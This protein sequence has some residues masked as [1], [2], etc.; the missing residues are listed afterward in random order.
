MGVTLHS[1]QKLCIATMKLKRYTYLIMSIL[2]M[3]CQT[4]NPKADYQQM[5][6][7]LS[8]E[9]YSG[10]SAWNDGDILAAR[11]L[12]SRLSE[13]PDLIPDGA[14]HTGEKAANP[15]Y[16]SVVNPYD[17]GRW[18]SQDQVTS[19]LP[20]LQHFVYPMNVMLGDMQVSVDGKLLTPTVDYTAKEFSPTTHGTYRV[21]YLSDSLVTEEHFVNYLNSGALKDAFAVINFTT[22][23]Q[24]PAHPYERYLPYIGKLDPNQI[25][26]IILKD[27]EIFPYFKARSYYQT[28]VPVLCVNEDFP[29]D[30]HQIKVDIDAELLPEKDAHNVIA[31]LPGTDASRKDYICFIA[32]Y[33]H[34]GLMGRD[35]LFPGANDNASGVAMLYALAKHF[36]K[37]R[38]ACGVQFIWLDAEEENLL[39]AFY[40][41]ENPTR[42]LEDIRMVIDLDMVADNSDHLATE[43]SKEGIAELQKIKEINASNSTF[44]PFD[45]ALQELS[46]ASDHYAF[47]EKGV[48]AVYFSTEG[49]FLQ[50]Y[51]TPRDRKTLIS[52]DNFE[53]LFYLIA[54]YVKAQ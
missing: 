19:F 39:G 45:I 28:P 4:E 14:T 20:Y 7:E 44:P 48:P 3:G 37:H 22:Y 17:L 12:I 13:I 33:D 52:Y 26:G 51:H 31:Y 47:S 43:C 15:H 29:T 42:R 8:S 16:K 2:L 32:H 24:L 46:D 9:K 6:E 35:N 50:H 53:R 21:V 18:K 25:A 11:Y 40:Y 30:A 10:R 54:T 49:D 1:K 38:P 27:K 5:L 36:C 34:L 23:K 41:C